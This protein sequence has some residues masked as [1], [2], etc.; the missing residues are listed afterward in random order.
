MMKAHLLTIVSQAIHFTK[1]K[2][3]LERRKEIFSAAQQFPVA[4]HNFLPPPTS[5]VH[6]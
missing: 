1:E 2:L 4:F 6:N 5:A 3:F